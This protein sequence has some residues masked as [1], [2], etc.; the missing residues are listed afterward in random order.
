MDIGSFKSKGA[1]FDPM[2]GVMHTAMRV[3]FARPS[4]GGSD[5]RFFAVAL[6][7]GIAGLIV[8]YP[9]ITL[10][11]G[12]VG[13]W[14]GRFEVRPAR[15]AA[16]EILAE[17]SV[18]AKFHHAALVGTS[19]KAA[20]SG[21]VRAFASTTAPLATRNLRTTA[22]QTS[23]SVRS[24]ERPAT[25]ASLSASPAVI[26]K[27]GDLAGAAKA[28]L[29][30]HRRPMTESVDT[31]A[32]LDAVRIALPPAASE[33]DARGAMRPQATLDAV[34]TAKPSTLGRQPVAG[35]SPAAVAQ[36]FGLLPTSRE[37]QE[38]DLAKLGGAKP[39]SDDLVRSAANTIATARPGGRT[40][41]LSRVPKVPDRV[42]GDHILH[43]AGL[44]LE[45]VPSG[46]LTVRIGMSGDLS[47]K[48]ADLLAPVQ[49]QM[50]PEA[51]QHLAASSAA[52]EYVSFAQLRAAGFDIR[53][54]AGSD[55]LMVSAQP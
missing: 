27:G 34:T 19:A 49:D 54:D 40:G 36:P 3:D 14:T 7:S 8:T 35:A 1:A 51:F 45:G 37:V 20:A 26:A 18:T 2:G 33:L 9:T 4:A 39:L 24:A 55:R 22:G 46:S 25:S 32:P 53:Y 38:F 30:G 44:S 42:V 48:L 29:T 31:R 43:L 21:L 12:T 5:G 11:N 23:T 16:A 6:A 50:A 47:I 41:D 10:G 17:T 15:L 52:S 13:E 28:P